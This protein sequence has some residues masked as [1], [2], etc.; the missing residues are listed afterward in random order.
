[1]YPGV[2][3]TDRRIKGKSVN[4]EKRLLVMRSINH[5][6]VSRSVGQLVGQPVDV[7]KLDGFVRKVP[8]VRRYT[9]MY[10]CTYIFAH[11]QMNVR[12]GTTE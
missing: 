1:M 8:Y 10:V 2:W 6:S 5:H 12:R 4:L 9:I 7:R 3:T 11:V